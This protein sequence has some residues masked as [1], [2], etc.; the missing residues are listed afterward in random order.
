MGSRSKDYRGRRKEERKQEEIGQERKMAEGRD[1]G[2]L[3]KGENKMNEKPKT[4]KN[5]GGT[6]SGVTR[7][8]CTHSDC[9]LMLRCIQGY[10][11]IA[12]R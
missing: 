8:V 10:Y 4:K 3:G 12:K 1:K 2:A 9:R 6:L 7:C 5:C 11:F